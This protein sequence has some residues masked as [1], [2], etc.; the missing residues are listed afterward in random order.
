MKKS[1]L[2]LLLAVA[3]MQLR[4]QVVFKLSLLPG[5]T[6]NLNRDLKMNL[7]MGGP[8]ALA[9]LGGGQD[10]KMTSVMNTDYGIVTGEKNS[11]G[12]TP[13]E[14]TT[15]SNVI[16]MSVNGREMPQNPQPAE[17]ALKIYGKFTP[18]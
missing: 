18:N 5:T 12:L 7:T 11:A 13:A 9:A 15:K 17:G 16:K 10:I 2:L 6:Y 4:A 1:F 14:F 8:E 3:A